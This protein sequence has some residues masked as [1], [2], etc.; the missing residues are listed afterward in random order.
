MEQNDLNYVDT[1]KKIGIAT[2]IVVTVVWGLISFASWF[3]I[4]M[5]TTALSNLDQTK[6]GEEIN[7]ALPTLL[8]LST[9]VAINTLTWGRNFK[10]KKKIFLISIGAAL[11]C[12]AIMI[13]L[14][15]TRSLRPESTSWM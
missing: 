1:N 10:E 14:F 3:I 8:I 12:I 2:N 6:F 5:L 7:I 15:A 4:V 9:N 13:I 11:L